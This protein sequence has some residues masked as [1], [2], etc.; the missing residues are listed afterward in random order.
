MALAD[1]LTKLRKQKG[2]T[3]EAV[4]ESAGVTK[5][6]VNKY[7]KGKMIPNGIVLVDI[8]DKLGTT[9]EYLVKGKTKT[10]RKN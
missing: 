5:Q 8:A 6:A 9:C 1:N 7:E 10:E 3:Q 4:A 2:L